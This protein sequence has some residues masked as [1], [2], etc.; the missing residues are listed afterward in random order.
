MRTFS[1]GFEEPSFNELDRARAVS[2]RYGTIHRELVLEARRR[3][4]ASRSRRGL[5]RAVR[6]LV[7]PPDLS[8]LAAGGRRRQGC[9]VG[10]GRRRAVRRLHTY[11][12][13][14][15]AERLRWSR[16]WSA[17]GG[18]AAAVLDAAHEYRLHGQA[19][20]PRRAPT[21]PSSDTRA[22]RRSSPP[23]RARSCSGTPVHGFD[24]LS[25]A[26]A[27][28]A[29]TEGSEMSPA[30]RTSTSAATWSTTCS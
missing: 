8:R 4:P 6:R 15:V 20:R 21:R 24:P 13:D 27:R 23:T 14:A 29:E 19:L 2:A 5:R 17:A 22:G 30:C 10:R 11:A 25:L 16:G 7:C 28:F 12:A 1:I 9:A 26:R 3:A 18:R